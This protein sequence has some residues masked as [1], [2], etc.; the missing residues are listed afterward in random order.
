MVSARSVRIGPKL[1][2]VRDTTPKVGLKENTKPEAGDVSG[3]WLNWVPISAF[4]G[5]KLS[6]LEAVKCTSCGLLTRVSVGNKG[7]FLLMPTS[8]PGPYT[9]AIRQTRSPERTEGGV[10]P[11]VEFAV[12]Q[13]PW[14][15]EYVEIS[16]RRTETKV[17][18]LS[19][20]MRNSL[21][22]LSSLSSRPSF[23]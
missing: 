12:G 15:T 17:A 16:K 4:K 18:T 19:F 11:L 23:R 6:R 7:P 9:C 3:S 2:V 5:V 13:G 1:S 8:P 14:A 20:D 21:S 22:S 10:P